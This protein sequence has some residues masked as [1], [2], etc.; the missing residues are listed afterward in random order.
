MTA[1][2]APSPKTPIILVIDD[3]EGTRLMLRRILEREAYQVAEAPDGDEGL[4][5]CQRVHPDLILLD[6]MMPRMTGF[7]VVKR[8]REDE[9]TRAIPVLMLT[10]LPDLNDKVRGLDLGA[11]DFL[12]KPI[13][14]VELLARVRSLLRIRYLHNELEQRNALLRNVLNRYVA[15]D[16]AT[17]IL[18]NPVEK[19]R[20][21]GQT[22]RVSVLFADIRGF[23]SFTEDHTAP[24]VVGLINLVFK[25]LV[26]VIF[27]HKG[28]FDKYL[29]DAVMAFYGAPVSYP[30]DTLRAVQTAVDLQ[31]VFVALKQEQAELAPLGLGIGIFTGDAVVGNL[32]SE[33]VMDYTVI[34]DVPNS[35]KR[36]QENA[37]PGQILICPATC[38]AVQDH[39]K[40]RPLEPLLL[41]G[42]KAPLQV[43]EVLGLRD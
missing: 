5:A 12:R 39:V 40:V 24:V 6:G 2:L 25:R 33:Q 11:D 22:S 42:K 38:E 19:L 9:A 35:A 29:G 31:Q 18:T 20:L 17:D 21:G 7:E 13:N 4:A 30:D 28:T 23:T 32:G 34:G 8:L 26:P 1:A 15:E 14:R 43:F 10:A 16:V 36:L 37:G 3:D 27:A 41:K